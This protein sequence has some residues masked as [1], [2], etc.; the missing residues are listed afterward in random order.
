MNRFTTIFVAGQETMEGKAAIK[1]LRP[2]KEYKIV[3]LSETEPD[4]TDHKAVNIYFEEH[5]PNTVLLFAGKL[6]GIKMNSEMPATLMLNNLKILTNV[7]S[8]AHEF[9]TQKLMYLASSCTYPKHAEQPMSP[10]MIM[11]GPLEPTNSAYATAKIAGIELCRAYQK[12][13][14]KNFLSIIPANIFGPNDDFNPDNS[15]VVAALIRKI[16]HAKVTNTPQLKIW[17]SGKPKREF[18]YVDNLIDGM[19]FVLNNYNHLTTLNIGTNWV[20]SISELAN[21]IKTIVGYKG[22]FKY[23]LKQEDGSPN[24]ILNSK[25]LHKLGWSSKGLTFEACIQKTYQ[26]YKRSL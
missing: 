24:K 21:I 20:Y 25:P 17:G 7:I 22:D 19:L 6:G 2:I 8:S 14:N 12:E 4:F 11:S 26:W 3:N 9:D 23:D 15:H 10:E 13:Y 16:H 18:I 1:A 5:K